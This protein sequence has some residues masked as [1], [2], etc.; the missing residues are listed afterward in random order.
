M[1]INNAGLELLKSFEGCRLTSYQDQK[2]IWTIGWGCTAG[3]HEGQTITQEEADQMLVNALAATEKG[4]S[5]LVKVPLTSYQFSALVCFAYNVGLGALEHS[6]LLGD[7]NNGFMDDAANQFILWDHC[8][9]IVDPGLL[10][11][12]Q[13]EKQLFRTSTAT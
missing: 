1:N 8:D 2:G 9:G 12:R 4:V 6:T 5:S 3:V 7:I 10:R 13:A 11:R